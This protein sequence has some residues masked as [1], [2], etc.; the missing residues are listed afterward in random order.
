MVR[1]LKWIS[2]SHADLLEFPPKVIKEVGYALWLAQIG[3]KAKNAKPLR[4]MGG[5]S[6]LEI[7]EDDRSGTYRVVSVV[8]I[9]DCVYVL[10]AFQKK[11][12]L[13]LDVQHSCKNI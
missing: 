4:G 8:E 1:K 5:A 2:S 7:V 6:V 12:P 13:S 11:R 9:E 10:H 3:R